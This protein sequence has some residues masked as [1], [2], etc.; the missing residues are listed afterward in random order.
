MCAAMEASSCF[1]V[2]Y[3]LTAVFN[4][5]PSWPSS[6]NF[7]AMSLSSPIK[8]WEA[9]AEEIV[10]I[11]ARRADASGRLILTRVVELWITNWFFPISFR[12]ILTRLTATTTAT[13]TASP[14]LLSSVAVENPGKRPTIMDIRESGMGGG[15]AQGTGGGVGGGVGGGTGG[16]MGAFSALTEVLMREEAHNKRQRV[17]GAS[18]PRVPTL[19]STPRQEDTEALEQFLAYDFDAVADTGADVAIGSDEALAALLQEEAYVD[20]NRALNE[21]DEVTSTN[22]QQFLQDTFG[23]SG[24]NGVGAGVAGVEGL[25]KHSA[26]GLQNLGNTCWFNAVIQVIFHTVVTLIGYFQLNK[27]VTDVHDGDD[28]AVVHAFADL[29]EK[30]RNGGGG[31]VNPNELLIAIRDRTPCF[32]K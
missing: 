8:M 9:I 31:I 20:F 24:K 29:M 15:M 30:L 12:T 19:P 10:K 23:S 26:S 2:A 4:K 14:S 7:A 3:V 18:T 5:V 11:V 25:G 32:K 21:S 6:A 27:H 13:T 28:D 1:A 22:A 16:G 17:L